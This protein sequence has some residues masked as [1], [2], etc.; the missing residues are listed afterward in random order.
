M[1][2]DGTE[3][4]T[5]RTIIYDLKGG[6]GTLRKYNALY[7]L[8]QDRDDIQGLWWVLSAGP[9]VVLDAC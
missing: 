8:T 9:N 3:T 7:D 5:P 1:G 2:A 4:F 6:F